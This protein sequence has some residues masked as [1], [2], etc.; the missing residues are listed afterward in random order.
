VPAARASTT[1]TVA[2]NN[3]NFA[4]SAIIRVQ[5]SCCMLN[6]IAKLTF[7]NT[8]VAGTYTNVNVNITKIC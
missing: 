2:G 8:G 4:F 5:P 3:S 1:T 6:N 7:V